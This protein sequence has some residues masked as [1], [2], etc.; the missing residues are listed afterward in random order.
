LR[1]VGA[2]RGGD[3]G[4]EPERLLLTQEQSARI[5]RPRKEIRINTAETTIDG[6]GSLEVK[7]GKSTG[8][9]MLLWMRAAAT[10]GQ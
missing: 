9:P 1:P 4:V 6:L 8:S 2:D 7:E 3:V 10:I 5:A